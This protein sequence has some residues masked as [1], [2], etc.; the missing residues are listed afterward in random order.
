MTISWLVCLMALSVGA[1]GEVP[2]S[3]SAFVAQT[4]LDEGDKS[5]IREYTVHYLDL[6]ATGDHEDVMKA[7]TKLVEPMQNVR[8]KASSAFRSVYAADLLPSL[9]NI[10]DE[11]DVYRGVNA[12]QVAGFL[13]TDSSIRML[14][15]R[16]GSSDEPDSS[17]RLWVAIALR[18][19]MANGELSLRS[20]N[21]AVRAL[22]EAAETEED[23]RVL[24]RQLET[25]SSIAK[26]RRSRDEGG[27]ELRSI[28]RKLQLEMIRVTL[29]RI[30]AK[31][32]SVELVYALRPSIFDVQQ[33]YLDPELSRY[34]REVGLNMAPQLARVNDIVLLHY[35][36]LQGNEPLKYSSGLS[37]RL[38]DET[39]RLIESDLG[40]GRAPQFN[41]E[42]LWLNKEKDALEKNREAWNALLAQPP[43]ADR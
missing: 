36:A 14:G 42:D 37:L 32:G 1:N 10:L 9:E 41:P 43:Y 31:E 38:S 33:Q 17:K 4:A 22:A 8:R 29:D 23:W 20:F 21:A 3:L 35:E 30:L 27:E 13:G 2:I 15:R 34:R 7:R 28:G 11:G 24:V 25:V 5:E 16:A 6:L 26:S 12:I 18:K 19:S 40:N 39:L